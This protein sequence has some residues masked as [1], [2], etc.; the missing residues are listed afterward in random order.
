M[1]GAD[2]D[3]RWDDDADDDDIK[4]AVWRNNMQKRGC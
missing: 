3:K 2:A 1:S 4:V